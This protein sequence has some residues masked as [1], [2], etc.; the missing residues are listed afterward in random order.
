[1]ARF[2]FKTR[3][4]ARGGYADIFRD[5]VHVDTIGPITSF[6]GPG[7]TAERDKRAAASA[8]RD[9]IVDYKV[10]DPWKG[11]TVFPQVRNSAGESAF[12]RCVAEVA[13]RGTARDPR[14]VCATA[15]R[16]KYGQAE[17]SRRSLAGR[18]RAARAARG[19]PAEGAAAVS[20]EFHGRPVREIIKVTQRRHYHKHLAELGK[21][22][23]LI[24][25]TDDGRRRVKMRN[26]SGALLCANEEKNQLYILGGNQSAHLRDFGINRPH[27]VEDLGTIEQVDYYT[28][29]DHLGSQGGEA[30]Y[31]H[32]FKRPRPS[33]HFRLRDSTLEI[34]GGRYRITAEGIED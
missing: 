12:D 24:V 1:M 32:K 15:G 21:L 23:Q 34:S 29:K 3:A 13:A 14:A 6:A 30:T 9:R 7:N 19:N 17:M 33:L 27:E 4:S 20:E 5:G 8:A 22:R 26:F 10:Y 2:S 31:W 18:R 28:T 25:L 11:L 16:S